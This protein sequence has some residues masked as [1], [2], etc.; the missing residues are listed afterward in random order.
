MKDLFRL[1]S[2]LRSRSPRIFNVD[3]LK[4]PCSVMIVSY[5]T[6]FHKKSLIAVVE[7]LPFR[8]AGILFLQSLGAFL[9]VGI[10][11]SVHARVG[12]EH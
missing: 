9:D 3:I 10:L 11:N 5:T 8:K 12:L 6:S 7:R 1:K 4:C 2:I